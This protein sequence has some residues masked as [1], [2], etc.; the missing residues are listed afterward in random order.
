[1]NE[2]RVKAVSNPYGGW[3]GHFTKCD[4][5]GWHAVQEN[6]ETRLFDSEE[7][8]LLAAYDAQNRYHFGRGILR[9]GE[10]ASAAKI[11]AGKLFMGNRRVVEVERR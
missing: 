10:K 7:K 1:M 3:E 5:A 4:G 6:G 2:P 8:A 11:E 9:Q